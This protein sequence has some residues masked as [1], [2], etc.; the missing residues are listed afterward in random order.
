MTDLSDQQV[1]E[2]AIQK[3]VDGGWENKPVGHIDEI[4]TDLVNGCDC[5]G[6]LY[7]II[8]NHGFAKAL[9]GEKWDAE[10]AIEKLSA[11]ISELHENGFTSFEKLLS[12]LLL[13]WQYHLQQMVIAENPIDYLREHLN[14]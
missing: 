14:D 3:A 7:Y 12:E 2:K 6:T 5:Y 8:F 11:T 13:P 10:N 9:W 4:A 1:L